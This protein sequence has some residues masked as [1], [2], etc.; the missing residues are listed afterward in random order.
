MQH[1]AS[2]KDSVRQTEAHKPGCRGAGGWLESGGTAAALLEAAAAAVLA[3]D[4]RGRI[5]FA[6]ARAESLFGYSRAEFAGRPLS[7]LLPASLR[8]RHSGL[9]ASFFTS[10]RQRP[11]GDG[12]R[13]AALR[14]DGSEFPAEISLSHISTPEGPIAL[15]TVTDISD[16]V[17]A[18]RELRRANEML[19]VIIEASPLAIIAADL[20]NR[21]ILWNK[22]AERIFGWSA[23]EVIGR[24][25]PT[26][27]SDRENE[28]AELFSMTASGESL[29]NTERVRLRKDGSRVEIRVWTSPM[30]D[31][32]G[33]I[34]GVLSIAAEMTE[35]KRL[36]AQLWRSQ[37]LEALGRLAGGVAHDFNNLL[38]VIA[39]YA[40]MTLASLPPGQAR[41]GI[42]EIRRTGERGAQL[43]GQLLA[44]GR[45]QVSHPRAADLNGIV[46]EML[47]MLRRTLGESHSIQTAGDPGP[48][49]IFVDPVQIEQVVVNLVLNARD[50]MPGG[51]AITIEISRPSDC[52]G[53]GL[54]PG[55]C[56]MLAVIDRG[57]GMTDEIRSRIF[58]P[59]FSTKEH[60][61]GLGLA[62]VYGIVKQN[63]GEI[64]V[65]S[66]P[67]LGTT[68]KVYFPEAAPAA[69][70]VLSKTAAGPAAAA[71]ETVLLTED[72]EDVRKLVGSM[73]VMRGYKV[74]VAGSAADALRIAG[75][76][77]GSIDLL[78]TDVVMPGVNGI[79]LANGLALLRPSMKVLFM[80]GYPDFPESQGVAVTGAAFLQKPF[81]A[82][83]LDR[84]IRDALN[85]GDG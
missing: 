34:R 80:S 8:K 77:E 50:A 16:R 11:M 63:K 52:T 56:V 58:E 29:V 12:A 42:E 17:H 53:P 23:G 4:R 24:A 15:A 47:G 79:D 76:H 30:R 19:R 7:I 61:A 33:E 13:F 22:A 72:D 18:E 10:P 68:F 82:D 27:P 71:T 48:A 70:P 32:D 78:L 9:A 45:K 62:T 1:V 3:V 69:K 43:T 25:L 26:V 31:A 6:N 37:K 73:L 41:D 64:W 5:V 28:L 14:K 74:L 49:W 51:G 46:H 35:F 75:D 59:F 84:R 2:G 65:D 60:G 55:R 57:H 36:E 83:M 85:A 40:E 66:E 20:N 54:G 44:F 21:T 81:T 38:T 67:D 39:G